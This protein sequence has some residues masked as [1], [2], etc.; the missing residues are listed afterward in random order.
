MSIYKRTILFK[1]IKPYCKMLLK[2]EWLSAY[3]GLV[4]LVYYI[5]EIAFSIILRYLSFLV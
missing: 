1:V 5:L 4:M 3:F 2:M